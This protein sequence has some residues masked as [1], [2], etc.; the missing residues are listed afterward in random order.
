MLALGICLYVSLPMMML[1]FGWIAALITF[2]VFAV[3]IALVLAR[4]GL[5]RARR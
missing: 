5:R 4:R 3:A 2:D 1:L